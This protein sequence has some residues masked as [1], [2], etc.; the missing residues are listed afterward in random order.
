MPYGPC[1]EVMPYL[2]RRAQENADVMGGASAEGDMMW[3]EVKRRVGSAW[4]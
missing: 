2:I 3:T 1:N 4:Y